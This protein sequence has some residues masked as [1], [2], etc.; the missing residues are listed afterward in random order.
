MAIVAKNLQ[1]EPSL[2]VALL[3]E[4]FTS[5]VYPWRKWRADGIEVRTVAAPV[6]PM[7]ANHGLGFAAFC[8][9]FLNGIPLKESRLMRSGS[10]NFARQVGLAPLPGSAK[11]ARRMAVLKIAC[12]T[13]GG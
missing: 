8:D 2:N 12:P 4:M 5:N 6:A 10:D 13:L 9:R 1:P 11:L 7:L 3:G